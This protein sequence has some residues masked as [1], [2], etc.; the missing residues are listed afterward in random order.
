MEPIRTFFEPAPDR[1]LRRL[2]EGDAGRIYV[3]L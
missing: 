2:D 3:V 1:L